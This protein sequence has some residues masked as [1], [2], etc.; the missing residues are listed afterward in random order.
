MMEID[1]NDSCVSGEHKIPLENESLSPFLEG[2][3]PVLKDLSQEGI[4]IQAQNL[5]KPET[6]ET[7]EII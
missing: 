7:P 4:K 6:A 5:M 2:L 1:K 3:S